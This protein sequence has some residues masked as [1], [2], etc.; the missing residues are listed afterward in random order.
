MTL[1][2]L[3]KVTIPNGVT[4]IGDS[5]FYGCS[6]LINVTIPNSV[7]S[8]GDSAFSE[9]GQTI[10]WFT[11]AMA[12]G[13]S[14]GLTPFRSPS[15]TGPT[16]SPSGP[17]P[18]T[19]S[20]WTPLATP[21]TLLQRQAPAHGH[22]DTHRPPHHQL[23]RHQPVPVHDARTGDG[24]DNLFQFSN[25][26]AWRCNRRLGLVHQLQLDALGRLT[27]VAFR[28]ARLS[29][30]HTLGSTLSSITGYLAHGQ[31]ILF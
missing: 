1:S 6:R 12:D 29:R 13:R 14:Y 19:W 5:T 20:W 10:A 22:A 26:V 23:L 7:A 11:V 9:R 18:R 30:R 24:Q 4:S 28:T 16:P 27:N 8:I 15:A 2:D 21:P 25:G 31:A 17:M 3:A